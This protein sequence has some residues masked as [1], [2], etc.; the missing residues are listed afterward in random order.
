M[1]CACDSDGSVLLAVT[2]YRMWL[3]TDGGVNWHEEQPNGN[4]DQYWNTCAV[5]AD[6][7]VMIAG[8]THTDIYGRRFYL[9]SPAA[10]GGPAFFVS[11]DS[12][13]ILISVRDNAAPQFSVGRDADGLTISVPR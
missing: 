13:G 12:A 9:F 10:A 11:R 8:V 2:G 3:S 6:G 1:E 7:S 4:Q 5:D